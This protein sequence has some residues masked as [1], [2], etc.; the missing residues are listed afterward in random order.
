MK[1]KNIILTEDFLKYREEAKKLER[2]LRDTYNREDI[3]VD[4]GAYAGGRSEDDPLKDKGY[5]KVSFR[6]KSEVDPAEWKNLKN[7]LEAKGFEITNESNYYD[8]DID[9]DREFFPDIKF[10]FNI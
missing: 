2:E 6:T 9:D 4:M 8:V 1:L 3:F 5:G 7:F 10:Q